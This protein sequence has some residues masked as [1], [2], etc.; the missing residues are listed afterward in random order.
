MNTVILGKLA[1]DRTRVQEVLADAQGNLRTSL[2]TTISG[3]YPVLNR[4]FGGVLAL[5]SVAITTNATTVIKNGPGV[6][7]GL[8][9]T[10]AGTTWTAQVFDN[11]AGS[12]FALTP[13]VAVAQG[14]FTSAY[15]LGGQG[16][17]CDIGITVVTAGVTPG[18]LYALY[19]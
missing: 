9:S 16:I 13:A 14:Q 4:T 3:E 8:I 17:Y 12:G 2:G 1:T 19:A 5:H 18:S 10:A 6:F 15:V 11:T 7:Y